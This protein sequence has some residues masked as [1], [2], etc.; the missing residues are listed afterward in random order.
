VMRF[1]PAGIVPSRR[2]A[3]ELHGGHGA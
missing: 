3:A 1:R 2:L